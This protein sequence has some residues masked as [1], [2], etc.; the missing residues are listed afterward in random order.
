[1]NFVEKKKSPSSFHEKGLF[2]QNSIRSPSERRKRSED[3][4]RK[5][6]AQY[7][8]HR[9]Q[10][11]KKKQKSGCGV[12]VGLLLAILIIAGA[13]IFYLSREV[14]GSSRPESVTVEIPQGS[15]KTKDNGRRAQ[16]LSKCL[17]TRT[18]S[19]ELKKGTDPTDPAADLKSSRNL[20]NSRKNQGTMTDAP[21]N[22]QK[23][24]QAMPKARTRTE[25]RTTVIKNKH[26]NI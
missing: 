25:S 23:H 14:K 18:S 5:S 15:S 7:E 17:N 11:P 8:A 9:P 4:G 1:M 10:R 13:G 3:K 6:M 24:R 26:L 22:A 2:A 19:T 20:Q 12:L 16:S 21:I